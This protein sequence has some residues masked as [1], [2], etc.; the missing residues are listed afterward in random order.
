MKK[1][2]D[3]KVYDFKNMFDNYCDDIDLKIDIHCN[4]FVNH[5][6]YSDLWYLVRRPV[7]FC[8]KTH[9]RNLILSELSGIF[10]GIK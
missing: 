4:S 3:I 7:R 9:T 1:L 8:I 10:N 5:G 2:V 6:V